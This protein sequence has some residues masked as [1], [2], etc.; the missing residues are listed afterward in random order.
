MAAAAAAADAPVRIED[1]TAVGID[2]RAT[3]AV[4]CSSKCCKVGMSTPQ[5]HHSTCSAHSQ[6]AVERRGIETSSESWIITT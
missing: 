3:S 2:T 4:E 5:S 6:F 1:R